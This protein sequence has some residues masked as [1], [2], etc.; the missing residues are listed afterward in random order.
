[1]TANN[2]QYLITGGED[3]FRPKLINDINSAK[4]IDITVS[5]IR[6][7][8]LRLILDALIDALDRGVEMRILTGDYLNVTEPMALRHLLLLQESGADIRIFET[9]GKQSFHMK[10]YIFTFSGEHGEKSGHAY[11]GSSNISSSALNQGLEWNLKVE[12]EENPA[13]FAEICR[14][15][16]A[17]YFHENTQRLSNAWIAVYQ[18]QFEHQPVLLFPELEPE[19]PLLPPEPNAIQRAAL[20]ALKQTRIEGYKRGLVVMAT[21]LGKTWL[22]AFDS[23]Q[24]ASEKVLFVAHREEILTQAEYTF[25]RIRPEDK[26]A[27]Y[28]GL[29]HQLEA[30]MLFASIQTLG[31]AHHLHKF[32]ADHFDYIVVDEFH[33]AA[34]QTYRQ[35]LNHFQPRFLLG[36]TATPERTDQ[37]DILALCDDN[38]VYRRD[39][40]DGINS[41]LLSPFSYYGIADQEVDY[42]SI[43][44]RN[45][46]FDPEQL[47]NKL[48][49]TRRA[50]H[51]LQRW[52]ASKQTRTL[53]FCISKKHADYMADY[54]RDH[55]YKAVSVHSDS[56][57]RR[58]DALSKLE[59]AEIDIIFSV[60]LFNE[61]VDLPAIDTVLMLRPTDSKIIFL[62]QLGRG[63]RTHSLKEKL[64]VLDFIGNHVSFFRK[65][66]A[67]FKIGVSKKER[68]EF[69]RQ[70]Q[71]GTLKLPQG[72]FVNYDLDAID[73][74]A[75]LIATN[76]DTQ[77]QFYRSLKEA[78][79]R[80]PTLAEFY[81]ADGDVQAI[82]Q[83]HGQWLAF[84]DAEHDLSTEQRQ[85]LQR[86]QAF[87]KELETTTLTKSYKIVLLEALIELDGFQQ[88]VDITELA[89]TSFNVIQ[90]RRALLSDLPD[91]FRGLNQ[92]DDKHLKRWYRYWMDNPIN[93]WTGGNIRN[94]SRAFFKVENDRLIFQGNIPETEIDIFLEFVGEL[95]DYRYMQYEARPEKKQPIQSEPKANVISIEKARKQRIPYFPDLKIACG[96]F[97]VSEHDEETVRKVSLPEQY[98]HLDANRHFIAHATG[99]SMDGGKN[100]IKDGDYLLLEV[101]T[102]D[103]AG[104]IS[105]QIVAI[106]RQDVSGDDQ[107]VLRYV[108]K[109][110]SGQYE[111]IA[112]NPDYQTMPATEDLRTFA[113]LK[114]VIDPDDLNDV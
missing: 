60:D 74:L 97:K 7:S 30:D 27:R 15:F 89:V 109:R 9:R 63:L 34:A 26:V 71:T 25:V 50:K 20:L 48:A 18:K 4:R 39:M 61:G 112:N 85:C 64:V 54:F 46:K 78:K 8:G 96:H 91:R 99:N 62:Q 11:V 110:G 10:A 33:H 82:R 49:T 41:G 6:Q 67:L 87:F 45:G 70:V 106:E 5:F 83:H 113:R 42:Q 13:R 19:E 40:F 107:Y 16:E 24:L 114:A 100:P 36:L 101:I 90:R 14:K 75:K 76:I 81:Q 28:S 65:P 3:P 58:N 93:A 43:P 103:N 56:N 77:E 37:A 29:E 111:L 105:N 72:C 94:A 104:S 80:R 51:A 68:G 69:I 55:G 17:I 47:Q 73:F 12:L 32:A 79:E 21:G 95:I 84:V 35:L 23:V 53:A 38:L 59:Q 44:W 88:A 66:E 92:L 2:H 86:F 102:P 1:M 52:E 98:G 22:A 31:K 57:I 108:R